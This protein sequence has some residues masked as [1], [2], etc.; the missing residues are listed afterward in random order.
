M[1]KVEI[2]NKLEESLLKIWNEFEDKNNLHF[3][4]SLHWLQKCSETFKNK[5]I[6][7]VVVF[8]DNKAVMIMPF[9]IKIRYHLKFLEWIGDEVV[10]FMGPIIDSRFDINK[11]DFIKLW[12]HLLKAIEKV[13]IIF[14]NKQL[15]FFNNKK[16]PFVFFLNNNFKENIYIVD[17]GKK[18]HDYYFEKDEYFFKSKKFELKKLE[19]SDVKFTMDDKISDSKEIFNFIYVNK[20]INLPKKHTNFKDNLKVFYNSVLNDFNFFKKIRSELS[21]NVVRNKNNEIIAAN[22][23]IICNN[24]FYYLINSFDKKSSLSKYSPGMILLIKTL[25]KSFSRNY[26][27]FNF[28]LGNEFYK[29]KWSNKT[30]DISTYFHFCTLFGFLFYTLYHLKKFF[31]NNTI[32]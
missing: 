17:I 10:D 27:E 9:Q 26:N 15:K 21:L 28:G 14:L 23:G 32:K 12:T 6:I 2:F 4:S 31:L 13:D 24:I 19:F 30:L 29:K 20:F 7:I 11:S 25:E 18:M 16:N 5:K 3:Y 8:N 1:L 22:L